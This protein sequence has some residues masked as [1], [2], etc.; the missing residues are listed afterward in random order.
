MQQFAKNAAIVSAIL[1]LIALYIPYCSM[2]LIRIAEYP[3]GIEFQ[4][5]LFSILYALIYSAASTSRF[6]GESEG[7]GGGASVCCVMHVVH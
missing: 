4:V 1:L 2:S 3:V 6:R 7:V 5:N